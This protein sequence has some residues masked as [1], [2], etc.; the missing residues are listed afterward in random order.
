MLLSLQVREDTGLLHLPL[1][2]AKYALE[3]IS[4]VNRD[5]NHYS[6]LSVPGP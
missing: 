3:I 4:F 1:E 5:L 6:P 2:A